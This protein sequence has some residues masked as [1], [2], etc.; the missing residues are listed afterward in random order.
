MYTHIIY[1]VVSILHLAV[2]QSWNDEVSGVGGLAGE[3]DR[4]VKRISQ[5]N[6]HLHRPTHI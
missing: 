6:T 1:I 4:V 3:H 2:Y 5:R